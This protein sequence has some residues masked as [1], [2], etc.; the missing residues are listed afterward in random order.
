MVFSAVVQCLAVLLL[1]DM[2][3]NIQMS[4][5]IQKAVRENLKRRQEKNEEVTVIDWKY[6]KLS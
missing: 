3:I 4:R 1:V 6:N 5:K 2:V